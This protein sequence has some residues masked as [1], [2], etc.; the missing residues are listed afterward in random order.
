MQCFIQAE[1]LSSGLVAGV[2]MLNG[3][4]LGWRNIHATQHRVQW[5]W[6]TCLKYY[7]LS[8]TMLV[9]VAVVVSTTSQAAN[10]NR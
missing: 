8:I 1:T 4:R 5:T 3:S 7:A 10:A 9:A 2:V 6:L